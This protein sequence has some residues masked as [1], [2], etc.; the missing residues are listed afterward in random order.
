VVSIMLKPPV[1][2]GGEVVGIV[3]L[4]VGG[5]VVGVDAD[6]VPGGVVVVVGGADAW[7][8]A[9][10]ISELMIGFVQVL[11]RIRVV[12]TPPTTTLRTCRRSCRFNAI[13]RTPV[14]AARAPTVCA[15]FEHCTFN[16]SFVQAQLRLEHSI[17]KIRHGT[18]DERQAPTCRP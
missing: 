12:A 14:Y 18:I 5:K 10:A 8:W 6:V 11:G 17:G 15:L 3:A 16:T 4:V 1:V 2:V 9:G 7:A 13:R